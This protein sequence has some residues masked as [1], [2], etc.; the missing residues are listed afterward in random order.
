MQETKQAIKVNGKTIEGEGVAY[1][2]CHKIYI[3]EDAK[4]REEAEKL[5]Y[6]VYNMAAL[7]VIWAESCTLRFIQNWKLNKVY[8][9]QEESATF[10]QVTLAEEA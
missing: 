4:D 5:G 2:E 8:V 10:D 1:D 7:P 6:G 3:I 9:G